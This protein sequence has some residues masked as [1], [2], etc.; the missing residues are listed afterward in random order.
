M[1]MLLLTQQL[2]IAHGISHWS[3]SRDAVQARDAGTRQ[4][5]KSMALEKACVDCLAFA[6]IGTGM[7]MPD[8][9]RQFDTV[10]G[11]CRP[12]PV[13][14]DACRRTVCAFQ[15]QAPPQV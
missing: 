1:L 11:A 6:Q 2:G 13:T 3:G 5:V 4:P 9:Q 10:C 12:L 14:Q 8:H 15:A 7:T